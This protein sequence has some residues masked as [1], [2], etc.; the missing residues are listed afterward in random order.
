[1]AKRNT[2]IG[3]PFWMA[4]EVIQEV[5]YD[6][7]ADIWSVGITALEMAEGKPPYADIHPMRAIFM[8]P[9]RPPPVFKEPDQ[10]SHEFQDFVAKC[11]VKN[12][13][14]RSSATVL[15]KH[16]FIRNAKS[17]SL[18][19]D[20]V[21][22]SLQVMESQL[23]MDSE[24]E[25]EVEDEDDELDTGTTRI[26]GSD[27]GT[28]IAHSSAESTSTTDSEMGTMISHG[29][30]VN[31]MVINSSDDEFA[32]DTMRR[33]DTLHLAEETDAK[34]DYRPAFMDHFDR[35]DDRT[36]VAMDANESS[37]SRQT[38]GAAASPQKDWRRT[39][40]DFDYLKTLSVEELQLRLTNLDPEME[41]EL[42]ELRQRYQAKRKPIL[43]AVNAKKKKQK[44][45]AL[46]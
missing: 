21:A 8:I 22:E 35:A 37:P 3:T 43:D 33:M 28:M 29:S 17:I 34:D 46:A 2:V 16:P 27:T 11:L 13:E 39:H 5:G 23:S 12:P 42:E 1:M 24:D 6:C 18:L 32:G 44:H 26:N 9:T 40:T 25:E 38:V 4:P 10:W 15:L 30:D 7:M 20:M 45:K 19:K 14:E 31:T 41:R 36:R